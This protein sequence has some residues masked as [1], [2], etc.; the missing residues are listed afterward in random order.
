MSDTITPTI[1]ESE[2][3]AKVSEIINQFWQAQAISAACELKLPDL[4]A[5]GPR[6]AKEVA[7]EAGADAPRVA[8][9]LR[10]LATLDLCRQGDDGAFELTR[11]GRVLRSGVPGSLRGMAMHVGGQIWKSWADLAYVVRTGQPSPSVVSGPEGFDAFAADPAAAAVFNQSMVD[12]SRRV[13]RPLVAS[14]DF[15]RFGTVMDVGG[16]YGAV[17]STLLQADPARSGI[18]FDLPYLAE[19]T[20]QF[21]A[22]EGVGERALFVG[23][24]FFESVPALADCYLLKYIIHD[25]DDAHALQIL[26]NC[27]IAA[28]ATGTVLLI[29]QIVPDRMEP[30]AAHRLVARGDLT[31]M[32]YGGTERTEAEYRA[33]LAAAGLRIAQIVPIPGGGFSVIEA[34]AA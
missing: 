13:A 24:S 30:T 17:L 29:E 20:T 31:M 33:I 8:R 4:L 16:G 12:G 34:V 25:W 15:S 19:G 32:V 23:G 11:A 21:L 14:Y 3:I 10:A 9:L 7:A 2:E 27:R 22:R 26:T 1:E 18:V 28:G 6:Q 5:A